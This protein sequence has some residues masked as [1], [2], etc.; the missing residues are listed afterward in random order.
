[1]IFTDEERD[2]LEAITENIAWLWWT[3][4]KEP[5]HTWLG[6]KTESEEIQKIET[7]LNKLKKTI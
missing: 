3:P 5:F 1:M 4:K 6:G 7:A 2:N